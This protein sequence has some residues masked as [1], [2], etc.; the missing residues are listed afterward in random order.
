M[1]KSTIIT[2]GIIVSILVLGAW[3]TYSVQKRSA[4]ND[5]GV[6]ENSITATAGTSY[7]DL[8]GRPFSFDDFEGQVRVV[9]SWA[10]WCPFCIEELPDFEKLAVQYADQNVAVIAV[11]RKEQHKRASDFLGTLG[12]FTQTH[13][14]IDLDDSYYVSIGG[15]SMPETLFYDAQGNVVFHKR[16]SMTLDE[17]KKHTQDALRASQ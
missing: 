9:N 1:S 4:F 6:K 13:F 12:T 3:Y 15:F 17:M 10:S 16:G 14:V 8:A 2:L 11:N 7:T 5:N